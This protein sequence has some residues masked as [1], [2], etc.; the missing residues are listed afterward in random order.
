[1]IPLL[2]VALFISALFSGAES[3]LL[4]AHRLRLGDLV[5]RARKSDDSDAEGVDGEFNG[6]RGKD[7]YHFASYFEL[8]YYPV[9]GLQLFYRQGLRTFDNRR[10][11]YFD[12]TRQTSLDSS[13]HNLG[14]VVRMGGASFTLTHFWNLEKAGELE[15]D[16]LRATVAYE[17]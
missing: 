10:G 3:V 12:R 4:S 15:D 2:V 17:F 11:L 7:Y 5:L 13:T 16:M 14:A 1:M 6:G 9:H 8:R